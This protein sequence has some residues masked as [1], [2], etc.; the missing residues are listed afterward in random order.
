MKNQFLT[1]GFLGALTASLAFVAGT[2][3]PANSQQPSEFKTEFDI[4]DY[5]E[6]NFKQWI[7]VGENHDL[8]FTRYTDS[9]S[10]DLFEVRC[11]NNR[12]LYRNVGNTGFSDADNESIAVEYCQDKGNI[13]I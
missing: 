3:V 5:A 6:H 9:N 4:V 10:T 13:H 1:I 12:T 11:L 2:F 7:A 8:V